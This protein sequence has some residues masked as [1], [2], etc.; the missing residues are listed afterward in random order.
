MKHFPSLEATGINSTPPSPHSLPCPKENKTMHALRIS[1]DSGISNRNHKMSWVGVSLCVRL[2][3]CTRM[4]RGCVPP[5]EEGRDAGAETWTTT[6]PSVSSW[7]CGQWPGEW[8]TQH[9]SRMQMPTEQQM[10]RKRS[11]G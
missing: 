5:A 11:L 1:H 8:D 7:H 3:L 10:C 4:L 9:L 2:S 6:D